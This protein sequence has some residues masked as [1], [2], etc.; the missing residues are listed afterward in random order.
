MYVSVEKSLKTLKTDY[1]DLV[2]DRMLESWRTIMLMHI[3]YYVHVW[4][5]STQIEELMQSLNYL[6]QQRKVLYLGVSDTPAYERPFHN[7][8]SITNRV[9]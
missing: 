3:Q 2:S 1:I 6:V 5:F 9:S 4:E 7:Y 8:A